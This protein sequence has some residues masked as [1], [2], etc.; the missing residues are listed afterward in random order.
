MGISGTAWKVSLLACK[1]LDGSGAGLLSGIIECI[2]FC[3]RRGA[4]IRHVLPRH[5]CLNT[6]L[7]LHQHSNA[8]L[9]HNTHPLHCTLAWCLSICMHGPA[10]AA[11]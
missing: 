6:A 4:K 10:A 8:F 1:F 2:S 7:A 5:P 9:K 3:L 11:Q